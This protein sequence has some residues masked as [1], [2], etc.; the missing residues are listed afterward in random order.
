[1]NKI[2]NINLGGYALTIDDDAHEYLASY[3]DSIRRRFSESEG[4]D[5]IIGDI[6]ARLGEL[7]SQGMGSRT[8]VMLPD[9]EAAVAVMGKPEDFGGEEAGG[10]S[11]GSS[12]NSNKKSGKATGRIGKRLFRDEDDAV[13]AG[14]CSGLSAYF[15]IQDPVW[16][17]LIFV[18][19]AFAS[20]GFWMP[21]Y[22]LIWILVPPAKTAA[23]R[24]AMRGEQV[25]MD[26]I[27]REVEEGFD[28]LGKK[29]K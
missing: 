28:R 11:S 29:S 16:M 6:E 27:A 23:D 20:F 10:S 24:L 12:S 21:A 17:R 15:G 3:L 14:V 8:I 18:V 2:L 25:N 19:L 9:A 22:V 26:N 13:V 1:M 4:R 5:E 7:I